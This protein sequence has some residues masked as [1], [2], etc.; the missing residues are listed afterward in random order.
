[1][2]FV[3][4]GQPA[5]EHG[6]VSRPWLAVRAYADAEP[7]QRLV[8]PC[9][10]AMVLSIVFPSDIEWY[11][12]T[13]PDGGELVGAVED[14]VRYLNTAAQVVLPIV[15]RD[16]IGLVQAA[17]VGLATTAATHGLKY[18]LDSTTVMG[19]RLG[20]RPSDPASRHNMPSGHASMASSAA[21]FVSRRYGWRHLAYLLP[22]V[23]L[24]MYARVQV[25]AH[26]ISAVLAG[27]LIGVLAGML[28]TGRRRG[29]GSRWR[30]AGSRPV[31]AA[32]M[33][34]TR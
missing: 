3:T 26:T 11:R 16:A 9:A 6:P 17:Y 20:E 29:A 32:R 14:H 13:P 4:S 21:Y 1:M 30:T 27:A 7:P 22:I 31:A 18:A 2:T 8:L 12:A 33:N 5:L 23:L 34:P 19:V 25:D 15:H 10:L 28:L 24:T